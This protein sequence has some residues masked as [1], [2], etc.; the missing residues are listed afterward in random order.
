MKERIENGLENN[1]SHYE[2]PTYFQST[3]DRI[4]DTLIRKHWF[5]TTGQV[6]VILVQGVV[7][8]D[9]FE[10]YPPRA[11]DREFDRG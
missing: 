8:V 5:V 1:G 4:P 6:V 7:K 3:R 10:K 9:P 2:G 11:L